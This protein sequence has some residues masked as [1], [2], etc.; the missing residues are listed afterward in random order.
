MI[1]IVCGGVEYKFHSLPITIGRDSDN[2]LPIDDVKLSRRHCRI[3]RDPDGLVVEDLD[4]RNGTFVN[5]APTKRHVLAAGDTVLIGVSPLQIEWDSDFLPQPLRKKQKPRAPEE[6]ESENVR[7][8]ELIGLVREVASERDE[9]TLLR[10]ILDSA[11]S[12]TRAERGFLFLVTLHGLD[13]RVAR[14]S[15]GHNLDKPD[16]KISHSIA[17]EAVESGRP[18]LTEDAG[19]DARFA[20][21][22]SVAF[23]RLRSVI[24]VPLKVP[25]GP[26]GALYL[27]DR[28]ATGHFHAR[29]IPFVSAFAEFSAI[30]LSAARNAAAL[31]KRDDQLRL[32]RDRIG[33]LNSRLRQLLG[34]PGSRRTP[35][36]EPAA[37]GLRY[38]FGPIVGRSAAVRGA[39]ALLDRLVDSDLSVLF[40]GESGTG[41]EL[42]ARTLHAQGAR[43]EGRFVTVHCGAIPR[44]LFEA[45][46]FGHEAGAF[47]GATA[48]KEGLLEQADGGTLFLDEVGD[49]PPDVQG[50][51]LRVL[52]SGEVRR[53]GGTEARKLS[54]RILSAT[55]RDLQQLAGSGGFREDLFFRLA[56]A[57]C[58]VPALRERA[59]DIPLLFEHFL[60]TFCAEQGIERPPVTSEVV[61]R[62]E[63][64]P[65]PGNVRELRNEVQRLLALQ[66]GSITP[67][68][69]SLHVFS[70]DP[71]AAPP[72]SL[73]P[74]GLKELIDNLE[75][76]VILDTLRRLKGNKTRS[77]EILGLSRLGLRKKIER[78]GLSDRG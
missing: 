51:L 52:E 35:R 63:A 62:L 27:E 11:I 16:E 34:R 53:V 26:L 30:A 67:D 70:G 12:L 32:S 76:R 40:T 4:S 14:D 24:C 45:E 2:D 56:G 60:D 19:G 31:R 78:F 42:F 37:Q 47:T 43:R 21:G 66:R 65:W 15:R 69:L 74:G 58:H 55:H 57:T 75:K 23:L 28:S 10:R 6:L 36:G 77:A 54:V 5:G 59:E 39:L 29:D 8:R 50:K 64:Y 68:L 48:A 49:T 73:P 71:G 72:A 38:D 13:Y 1:R 41:K 46:L 18:V 44:D 9:E 7:L 20:G 33:R 3:V 22:R 17:R 25:D 61:D